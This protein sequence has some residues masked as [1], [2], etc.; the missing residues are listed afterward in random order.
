MPGP[1]SVS[2][3]ILFAGVA[4]AVLCLATAIAPVVVS[5]QSDLD[6]FMQQVMARRDDNWKKLQ[7]YILDERE[8]IDFR[9]PAR[10]PLWGERRD[11]TWFIRDGFFVRSPLKVNGAAVGEDDRRKYEADYLR[12]QQRRDKRQQ[13]RDQKLQESSASASG[14]ADPHATADQV[15]GDPAPPSDLEG[16]IRQT[17]Q[18]EFISSAYFMDFK[19]D[20][21]RYALVGREQLNGQDVLRV[22]Y[23]PTRLFA[24]DENDRRRRRDRGEPENKAVDETV[25][26]LMNKGSRVTMWIVPSSHQIVQ[27]TFDNVN[28]DFLPA[29]WLAS[30][31]GAH[32]SMTMS[33]AFPDVWLPHDL[34]MQVALMLAIG[35]L[36]VQYSLNYHD[37]RQADV[38]A[39]I[40]VPGVR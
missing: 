2:T 7:Q 15:P 22:E 4:F 39:V 29:Q 28:F 19:F 18:P 35:E 30:V 34:H 32:A 10:I 25:N 33:Q 38:T 23:Y 20:S 11:F 36:T 3:T 31:S 14:Q 5:A 13:E 40:R 8:E 9:G 26:R 12:R 1:R 24:D 6:A 16:F 17:R 37:Y 21:G 27:Y